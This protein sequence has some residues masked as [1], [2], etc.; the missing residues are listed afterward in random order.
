MAKRRKRRTK[1]EIEK[2]I[3]DTAISLIEYRGFDALTVRNIAEK[4]D[5]EA[6][7]FY[8]RYTNIEEY[9]E[10]LVKK[11]DYWFTDIAKNKSNEILTEKDEYL[12]IIK[13]LFYSLDENKLMQQ[14]LRW[15]ISDRNSITQHTARLREFHTIPLV[16][17]YKDYFK[18]SPIDIAAVSA[19]I[20]GGIYYLILHADLSLF[21]GIDVNT[22]EGQKRIYDTIDLLSDILF[23]KISEYDNNLLKIAKR[24]KEDGM[25]NEVIERY[26]DIPSSI[27]NSL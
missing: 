16:D 1:E 22:E 25:E 12:Y 10:E 26:T 9:I 7:V 17:K 18:D 4:A 11:Q 6:V 19:L 24:M 27:I 3:D 23:N 5:I 8:N 15:E 14:L 2:L 20:I 21:A 13:N